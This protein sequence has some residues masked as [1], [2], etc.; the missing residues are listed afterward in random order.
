MHQRVPPSLAGTQ[1]SDSRVAEVG[2]PH[3]PVIQSS[4]IVGANLWYRKRSALRFEAGGLALSI[5]PGSCD[6]S[7]GSQATR[8]IHLA[9]G[10]TP[11]SMSIPASLILKVLE[12]HGLPPGHMPRDQLILLLLEHRF[13]EVIEALEHSLSLPITLRDLSFK[14]HLD[15]EQLMTLDARCRLWDKEYWIKLSLPAALA[16]TLGKLLDASTSSQKNDLDVPIVVASRVA[17]TQLTLGAF[18]SI[19]LGDVLLADAT[20]G[21][22]KAFIIVGE[23]FAAAGRW[24]DSNVTLLERPNKITSGFGGVWSMSDMANFRGEPEVADAELDDIQIR[25]IFELGRKELRLGDLR[26]LVPGHV[27]DLSRDQRT[28]VDI[29]AGTQ[30]VGLG[31]IVQVNDTLGVRVTRLFNNE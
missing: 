21:A 8:F 19:V 17:V 24:Q 27:F 23:R 1:Q 29:Y 13:A 25:V 3:F 20:A 7:S 31:E 16:L 9:V 10:D 30:R 2:L 14:S 4:A 15:S 5:T 26:S 12:S 18:R 28:A 11:A 6:T 22:G